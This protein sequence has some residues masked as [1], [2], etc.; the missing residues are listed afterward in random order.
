MSI[1]LHCNHC[2]KLIRAPE[3]AGGKH[4]TC[5]YCKQTVYIP[6]VA[7]NDDVIAVAPLDAEDERRAAELK[8][9][10]VEMSASVDRDTGG[11]YD[12]GDAGVGQTGSKLIGG[13]GESVEI[14]ALVEQFVL[15]MRDSKLDTIGQIVATLKRVRAAARD[16]VEGILTDEMPAPIGDLPV[17]LMKG[18]LKDLLARL[19]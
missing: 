11:K 3:S 4:G 10:S 5:P 7:S 1:E 15:A 14:D 19:Q 9:E 17:P 2:S 12:V 18:F 8:Q 16:H 13:L 6:T